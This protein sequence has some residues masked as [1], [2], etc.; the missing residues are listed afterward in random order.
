[1]R[2]HYCGEVNET[3]VGSTVSVAGWVHRRRDHGGVIFVDLRDRDGLLQVVFDPDAAAVFAEAERVRGEWVL[4]VTGTVRPR[5][6]GT[7]NVNLASGQVELLARDIEVLNRSEPIPFQL[8][9]EVREE[10]RLK[11][12][13]IDL[14]RDVMQKRLRLR[15]AITRAMREFLDTHGFIDVETPMLTKATPEGARDYLVPSRTQPG[16]FFALPQSPQIFKQLL[17]MAGFDRYY[18]IVRCFRDEDLRADRQP[19]FTQLD[20]ETSFLARDDIMSLMEGL[21]RK[22]FK[23]VL[24]QSLPEPF[25]RM[26]YAEAMRRYASDKPD[27]RIELELVDVADLVRDSDFKVF[28]GPAADAA[29]RVAALR[30][31]QGGEKLSRKQIDDY[32]AFVARY[33]AKGLAYVKVNDAAKGR[34][35]LQS[36]ILKFLSDAAITGLMQRTGAQTGDLIFFGADKAKVVNDALG[37][38]RLKV[39]QDLGLVREGW[40]PLWVVDFPMFEW[41]ADAKRWAA[42]HHPFTSPVNDDAAALKSNPGEALARAYDMV[43]NG[44]EIGGGSVRIHRNEMQ[45]TVFELLGIGAEEAERKFG[46]LLDALKFGAPPH[47]GIAFGLDRL[48]MLM[49]GAESIRDV[50]AFPKTQTATCL[51]TDAPTEVSEQQLR[52]LHIRV[53]LPVKE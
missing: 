20:V 28:S 40:A 18:Q 12:R 44:S 49:A 27:L 19:E 46:F 38:L 30:V 11:Y 26:S 13:Y 8:D 16:K 21:V 48:A 22:L 47:G 23:D 7:A 39:G 10:T 1:M 24:G 9:E 52:E 36:P 2:T 29:G 50:I 31:P 53:K 3:L 6:A 35:G 5:P 51:L 32:T 25:P 43:L 33:G 17:M 37:A 34:D 45:S 41:D 14:R 42:M 15:H 4:R